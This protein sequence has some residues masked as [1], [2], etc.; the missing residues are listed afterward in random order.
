MRRALLVFSLVLGALG[1]SSF[2]HADTLVY[3]CD[4]GKSV[5]IF[6]AQVAG[7]KAAHPTALLGR[8]AIS[9]SK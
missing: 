3:L 2:A 4:S 5:C 8:C 9:A 6:S 7:Y 1:I